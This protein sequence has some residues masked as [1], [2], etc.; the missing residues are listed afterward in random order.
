MERVPSPAAPG[1]LT[2]RPQEVLAKLLGDTHAPTTPARDG[3]K[4]VIRLFDCC[5]TVKVSY[6]HPASPC[7]LRAA[8]C[9][10]W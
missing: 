3:A 10:R 9:R 6:S 5:S 1:A 7:G 2:L 4:R 8:S